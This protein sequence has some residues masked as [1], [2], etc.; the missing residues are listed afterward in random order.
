MIIPLNRATCRL[1]LKEAE[2][3]ATV[4]GEYPAYYCKEHAYKVVDND[5]PE[6]IVNCPNC[7]CLFG[8]NSGVGKCIR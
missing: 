4:R 8:V 5:Q 6:F 2:Y 7:D 3:I 1:C